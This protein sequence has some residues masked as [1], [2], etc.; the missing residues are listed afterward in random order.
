MDESVF[1]FIIENQT[2]WRTEYYAN[3]KRKDQV[4]IIQRRRYKSRGNKNQEEIRKSL[5][6]YNK[7]IL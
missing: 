1:R 7:S 2:K 4:S 6:E 3:E 5:E